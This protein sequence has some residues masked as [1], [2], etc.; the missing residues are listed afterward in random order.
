LD[1]N[2]IF[3]D[4]NYFYYKNKNSNVATDSKVYILAI[5]TEDFTDRKGNR[6]G[7]DGDFP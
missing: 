2:W 7:T 1:T 6:W 4:T 5:K 3:D